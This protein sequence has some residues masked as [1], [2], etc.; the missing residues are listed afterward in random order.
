[1]FWPKEKK[2][3]ENFEPFSYKLIFGK[4]IRSLLAESYHTLSKSKINE[5]FK[6]EW[7]YRGNAVE[8]LMLHVVR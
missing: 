2:E 4:T 1:M 6:G 7:I 5:R 3:D 8:Y